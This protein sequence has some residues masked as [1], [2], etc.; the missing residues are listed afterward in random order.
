MSLSTELYVTYCSKEKLTTPGLLPAVERYKSERINQVA[1]LARQAQSD[2][3]ILSGKF[4]LIDQRREIAY[5]DQLL[6]ADRVEEIIPRS[7]DFL[8]QQQSDRVLFYSRSVSTYPQL[9]PYHRAIQLICQQ[10]GVSL[11]KRFYPPSGDDQSTG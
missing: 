3:A 6:T 10:A 1:R 11:V 5:Y 2:F 4:G 9:Q 7:V 8:Q